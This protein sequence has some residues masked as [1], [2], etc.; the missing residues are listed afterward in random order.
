MR[1]S[2][3]LFPLLLHLL[4]LSV[5]F[6]LASATYYAP[7]GRIPEHTCQKIIHSKRCDTWKCTQ[8]CSKKPA[9]VGQCRGFICFCTYFCKDPPK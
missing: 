3:M 5:V 7:V 1:I 9:G 6:S 4:L 8:E 2:W